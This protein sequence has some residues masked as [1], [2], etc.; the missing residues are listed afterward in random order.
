MAST[1]RVK[2]EI[3]FVGSSQYGENAN[4]GSIDLHGLKS[5]ISAANSEFREGKLKWSV[6]NNDRVRLLSQTRKLVDQISLEPSSADLISFSARVFSS[7][8]NLCKLEQGLDGVIR[9]TQSVRRSDVPITIENR[10]VFVGGETYLV[11]VQNVGLRSLR[12][13]FVKLGEQRAEV[14]PTQVSQTAGVLAA[15]NITFKMAYNGVRFFYFPTCPAQIRI[16]RIAVQVGKQENY[17]DTY[18]VDFSKLKS[19]TRIQFESA[20]TKKVTAAIS[21]PLEAARAISVMLE[22]KFMSTSIAVTANSKP[23]EFTSKGAHHIFIENFTGKPRVTYPDSREMLSDD[24][25]DSSD[26]E[27]AS[28][29]T[30][31]FD[32]ENMCKSQPNPELDVLDISELQRR[33]AVAKEKHK[34]AKQEGDIIRKGVGAPQ[35]RTAVEE[36]TADNLLKLLQALDLK[37]VDVDREPGPGFPF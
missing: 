13:T 11:R 26:Q 25:S 18:F 24:E 4:I 6:P 29:T 31:H 1:S 21:A 17:S 3:A 27:D 14:M 34:Q 15:E 8:N 33:L 35:K 12:A 23:T 7:Y 28:T 32:W 30:I 5:E 2:F 16:E 19:S 10:P 22:G 20:T 9:P 37:G 36:R